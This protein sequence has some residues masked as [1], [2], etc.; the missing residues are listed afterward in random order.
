MDTSYTT[1]ISIRFYLASHVGRVVGEVATEVACEETSLDVRYEPKGDFLPEE[2]VR[3]SA[4]L[5]FLVR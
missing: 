1:R 2:A 4:F 3:H 5:T